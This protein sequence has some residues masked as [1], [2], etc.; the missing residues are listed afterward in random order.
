MTQSTATPEI[1]L[2]TGATGRSGGAHAQRRNAATSRPLA[3]RN[4][5]STAIGGHQ[6]SGESSERFAAT[7]FSPGGSTCTWNG[8]AST[9][10]A[11]TLTPCTGWSGPDLLTW[12]PPRTQ[13]DA[14]VADGQALLV[15]GLGRVRQI[16]DVTWSPRGDFGWMPVATEFGQTL[17]IKRRRDIPGAFGS[18]P[19]SVAPNVR[20]AS[21]TTRP[22]KASSPNDDPGVFDRPQPSPPS[23][24]EVVAA[25]LEVVRNRRY[26]GGAI[27]ETFKSLHRDYGSGV[28]TA[29]AALLAQE[30]PSRWS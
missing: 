9:F 7:I 29:F 18:A 15:T 25:A 27:G 16:G 1:D 20:I 4:R 22:R 8:S 14:L 23:D 2:A 24:V 6:S 5:R 28:A 10:R 30:M 11:W 17:I 12:E 26:A 21:S 13:G 19:E 3:S